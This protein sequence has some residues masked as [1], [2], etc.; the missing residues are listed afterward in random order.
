MN[1]EQILEKLQAI[2]QDVFDDEELK[3]TEATNPEDI[4]DWDSIG[5]T[6]LKVEIEDEFNV[7]LGE[8]MQKI[9]NVHDIIE[10]V[11]EKMG[12]K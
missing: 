8:Q 11:V 6:Y 12:E 2:F 4:E 9:E 7:R 10:L 5:H 3:I 1:R